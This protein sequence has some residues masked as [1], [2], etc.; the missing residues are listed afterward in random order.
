[1]RI[2]W[3]IRLFIGALIVG[4]ALF[5]KCANTQENPYT[6]TSQ[7]ISMDPEQ[8]LAIGLQSALGIAEEYGGLYKDGRLQNYVDMTG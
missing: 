5:K 6:G 8:E 7:V 1:M 3:K 4:F 2:S